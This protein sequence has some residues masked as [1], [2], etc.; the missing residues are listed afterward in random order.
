M[1]KPDHSICFEISLL[2]RNFVLSC[3]PDEEE[4]LRKAVD[5]LKEKIDAIE[6]R[7]R[8]SSIERIALLAALDIAHEYILLFEA[9]SI[10]L[11]PYIERLQKLADDTEKFLR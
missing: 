1:T 7:S 11:E 5:F 3:K 2:G 9:K 6:Q 4:T 8:Q 10:P